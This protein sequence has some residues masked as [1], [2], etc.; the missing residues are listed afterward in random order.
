MKQFNIPRIMLAASASGSGKTTVMCALLSLFKEMGQ[1]A[2]AFKCGPDYIDPMFHQTVLQTPSHNLDIFLC[3]R[4]QRGRQWVQHLLYT[5]SKNA[6]I[7][8]LEG[9]MGFY[10]GLGTT[11]E[12]SAYDIAK[13][14]DTP[15]ILVINGKGAGISVA[16]QLQG[17]QNFQ[18]QSHIVGFIVNNVK[19]SVYLYF[20]E[21]VEE[22]TGLKGL[23]YVPPLPEAAL[24]SRHL[25]LVTAAEIPDIQQKIAFLRDTVKETIDS[26]AILEIAKSEMKI[27]DVFLTPPATLQQT[28]DRGDSQSEAVTIAVARDE[29]FC[30]YYE[31]SLDILRTL[32]ANLV[33]FSPLHDNHLPPCQGMYLGGG[34]PELHA[35]ELARNVSMRDDIRTALQHHM[36]CIAECGG[37]MYLQDG[38][39]DGDVMY[40][41]VGAI[42]G[43]NHMTESLTRFGYVTMTAQQ[44]TAF[45]RKGQQIQ[46][47]EFHYSDSTQNG[48]AFLIQKPTGKRQWHGG[49]VQDNL[50]SGYPHFH[51][52]GCPD[53]AARFIQACKKW[54]GVGD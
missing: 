29:A 11:W 35:V 26:Q 2:V 28:K 6:D 3:G 52:C 13:T 40:P 22:A 51:F 23:G 19:K 20:K 4:G 54:N 36:P 21:A 8:L 46:A 15:V 30:F 48:D 14:T 25:G 33:F 39:I 41:W 53:V 32:G 49:Y 7:A 16:A 45:L 47:H 12:N 37:F 31:A 18:L 24:P 44:D 1:K 27:S 34:Y 50:L 42:D 9:A 17:F 10:D 5:Y 38:F 43:T